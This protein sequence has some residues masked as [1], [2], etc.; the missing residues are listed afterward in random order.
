MLERVPLEQQEHLPPKEKDD[1]LFYEPFSRNRRC[2]SYPLFYNIQEE[3]YA[4]DDLTRIE[5][6]LETQ[7]VPRIISPS[8]TFIE[9]FNITG[10]IIKG[11]ECP[12]VQLNL[13]LGELNY[14]DRKIGIKK[15]EKAVQFARSVAHLELAFGN[16]GND[17]LKV[18]HHRIIGEIREK[19]RPDLEINGVVMPFDL[20]FVGD[21]DVLG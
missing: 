21:D 14:Y 17:T 3:L 8:G 11:L 7:E 15:M 12:S 10:E 9:A 20:S 19:V 16:T 18:E 1:P 2:N 4:M 13:L 6:I 5:L